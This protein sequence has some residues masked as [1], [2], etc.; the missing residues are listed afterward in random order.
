MC[1]LDDHILPYM[2]V[3]TIATI[4]GVCH[5]NMSRASLN[6]TNLTNLKLQIVSA[7]DLQYDAMSVLC[8]QAK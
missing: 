8:I 4:T 7:A 3:D 1:N 6:N 2:E 5:L